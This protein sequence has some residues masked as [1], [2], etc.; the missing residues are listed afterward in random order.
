MDSKKLKERISIPFVPFMSSFS[1][2]AGVGL[3]CPS[4]VLKSN[5][6]SHATLQHSW[7]PQISKPEFNIDKNLN[8]SK[9]EIGEF[10]DFFFLSKIWNSMTYLYIVCSFWELEVEMKIINLS[11]ISHEHEAK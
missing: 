5:I 9:P 1:S 6:E 10:Y 2:S 3:A 7:L 4:I 8:F 11:H